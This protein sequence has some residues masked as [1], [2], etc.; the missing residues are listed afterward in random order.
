MIAISQRDIQFMLA[1]LALPNE[2]RGM[3]ESL[4][5]R[6]SAAISDDTADTLRDL[7]TERFDTHGLDINYEP[8]DEGR[9]LELLVDK[10]LVK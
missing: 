2:L 10:L 4:L 5:K 3:L 6:D 1:K 8:T 9:E 7:C